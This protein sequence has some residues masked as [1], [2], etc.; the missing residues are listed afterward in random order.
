MREK[1]RSNGDDDDEDNDDWE[2]DFY[3]DED[4]W[5]YGART[6]SLDAFFLLFV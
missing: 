6:I 1:K 5:G 2:S 4:Q 3:R